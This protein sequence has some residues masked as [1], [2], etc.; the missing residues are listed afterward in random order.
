MP[1]G[2]SQK[3]LVDEASFFEYVSSGQKYNTKSAPRTT[4]AISG[5]KQYAATTH[6]VSD[7]LQGSLYEFNPQDQLLIINKA[8]TE[9][10]EG[11]TKDGYDA[12]GFSSFTTTLPSLSGSGGSGSFGGLNGVSGF[13]GGLTSWPPGLPEEGAEA[14][15]LVAINAGFTDS[16][17]LK[18]VMIA[19]RESHWRNIAR[20]DT[21]DTGMWQ[22]NYA[23]GSNQPR[24]EAM[25]Y[26]K[27]EDLLNP[28]DNAHVAFKIYQ[29]QGNSFHNAWSA[30]SESQYLI[31]KG[32][33]SPGNA[34]GWDPNGDPMWNTEEHEE[35]A[36][37]AIAKIL[38]MIN[39]GEIDYKVSS[40]DA[41]FNTVS[42]S[43]DFVDTIDDLKWAGQ[44][45]V[46]HPNFHAAQHGQWASTLAKH[47][48]EGF[49]SGTD[50]P[51]EYIA[52]WDSSLNRGFYTP[53]LLNYLWYILE[54][55]FTI[56]YF[57]G[58]YGH[59]DKINGSG[60]LS[61]HAHGGAMDFGS[62]G[63]QG[64]PVGYEDPQWRSLNDKLWEH[65][66]TFPRET[67]PREIGT[68]FRHTYSGWFTVYKDPN[69]THIHIGFEEDQIGKLLPVLKPRSISRN[70]NQGA[71]G[72]L[73]T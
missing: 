4:A 46:N 23:P 44:M 64:D 65:M 50:R 60:S 59:R 13:Q 2:P 6:S 17:L 12:H 73:A 19:G 8:L 33:A 70:G 66:A 26:T 1:S 38:G 10:L 58:G 47:L 30:S 7:I 52:I 29:D 28:I 67:K 53:S 37:A 22:I 68:T 11:F 56:G 54:S 31:D 5:A 3:N 49:H 34:A 72:I 43:G 48:T 36:A 24:A 40:I 14:C 61:N 25:G 16:D 69:P 35:E 71:S 9:S 63:Y 45:L 62:L 57:L 41:S 15:A 39:N 18:A 21:A 27:R 20:D 55:G 51:T 42:A 32:I